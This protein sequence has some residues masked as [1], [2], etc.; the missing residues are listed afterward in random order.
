MTKHLILLDCDGTLTDGKL[1]ITANN[2]ISMSFHVHDGMILSHLAKQQNVV[3]A[4]I[5]G[6]KQPNGAHRAKYLNITEYHP[7]IS[8]KSKVARALQKKYQT[9]EEQTIA[10]GDDINDIGMFACAKVKIAVA[11]AQPELKKLATWVTQ[12]NGGDGAVREALEQYFT[13]AYNTETQHVSQ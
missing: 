10:I 11:N 1:H 9:S 6:G 13:I 3:I 4:I 12:K 5:T 7:G 2:E 8:D